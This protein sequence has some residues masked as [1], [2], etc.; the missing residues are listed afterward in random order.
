MHDLRS[1]QGWAT[2]TPP[3]RPAR[4]TRLQKWA[5]VREHVDAAMEF[6]ERMVAYYANLEG[7]L[8]AP[9]SVPRELSPVLSPLVERKVVTGV[10]VAIAVAAAYERRGGV[11]ALDAAVGAATA[12]SCTCAR[13]CG[14][15]RAQA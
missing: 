7:P 13:N 15:W 10:G 4:A 2:H 5:E 14:W 11:P 6:D 9:D 8:C 12:Q 1:A 3:L